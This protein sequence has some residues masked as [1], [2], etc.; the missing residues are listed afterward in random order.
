MTC[1][2]GPLAALIAVDSQISV[3]REIFRVAFNPFPFNQKEL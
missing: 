2:G 1:T 3:P